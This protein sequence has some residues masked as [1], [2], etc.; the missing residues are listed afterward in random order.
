M[1]CILQKKL[2]Y[3]VD[4][5]EHPCDAFLLWLFVTL[6]S[7]VW[8]KGVIT[9]LMYGSRSKG[10]EN[11]IIVQS[12]THRRYL[13]II[14]TYAHRGGNGKDKDRTIIGGNAWK[15][16]TL[17]SVWS[18]QKRGVPLFMAPLIISQQW[19]HKTF[20][21]AGA[22]I[23]YNRRIPATQLQMIFETNPEFLFYSKQ[24]IQWTIGCGSF[25]GFQSWP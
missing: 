10:D 17:K 22:T 11:K 21:Y 8:S 5:V 15:T 3:T 2:F 6:H 1:L 4:N 9:V 20:T 19:G 7:W 12:K 24:G 18:R 25:P 16:R 14:D 23:N 13:T